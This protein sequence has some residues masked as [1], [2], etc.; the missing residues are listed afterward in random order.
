[1]SLLKPHRPS[2]LSSPTGSDVA[3]GT[4]SSSGAGRRSHLHCLLFPELPVTRWPTRI[5]DRLG[6]LQ[7]RDD[8][9]DPTLLQEIHAN[10]P[11]F[12]APEEEAVLVV[13]T[14]GHQVPP[15][16]EGVLS[17]VQPS[18]QRQTLPTSLFQFARILILYTCH[19]LTWTCIKPTIPFIELS[20]QVK[21][22][23]FL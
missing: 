6:R 3:E 4:P 13:T 18:H 7:P 5:P 15:M 19:G 8:I 10:Q 1:M 9:L 16:E 11:E 20:A 12:P 17:Q 22:S 14:I 2:L 23:K 21:K